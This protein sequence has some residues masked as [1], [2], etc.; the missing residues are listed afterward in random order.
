MCIYTHTAWKKCKQYKKSISYFYD[1]EKVL[2]CRFRPVTHNRRVGMSLAGEGDSV[3][4]QDRAWLNGQGH[5]WWI[6]RRA[7]NFHD[8]SFATLH[9]K[10]AAV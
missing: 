5:S 3:S 6:W 10:Y 4:L 7:R 9:K 8:N 2:V 1:N